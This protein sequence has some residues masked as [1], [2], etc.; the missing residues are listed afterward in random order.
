MESSSVALVC[1]AKLE[2]PYIAEWLRYNLVGLHFDV[3]YI[4][5]NNDDPE[6]LLGTLQRELSDQLRARV[7]V[8]HEPD[9][10]LLQ[11][12][13]Y[14]EWSLKHKHKH[15]AVAFF[16]LD[17]FLVLRKHRSIHELL[18]EHLYPYGG[19]LG[20]NW[21]FFGTNGHTEPDYSTPVTRRFTRR[22]VGVDCHV[23]SIALCSDLDFMEHPHCPLLRPGACQR[24]TAGNVFAGPFNYAGSDDVAQLNHYWHKTL[25]EW[26]IKRNKGCVDGDPSWRRPLE[27]W[28]V[29]LVTYNAIEELLA[30]QLYQR[31]LEETQTKDPVEAV[32]ANGVKQDGE[33]MKQMST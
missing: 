3:V 31:V 5:D 32:R 26:M 33:E 19:A 25:P 8:Q 23:K 30:C 16:D 14:K 4:Y 27:M 9:N 21:V 7:I 18:E 24:D 28:Q 10:Y 17:E 20:I 29:G 13:S 11:L 6:T 1:V 2:D 22:Q 15:R 12:R